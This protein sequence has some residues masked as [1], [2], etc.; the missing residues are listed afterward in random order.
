MMP[1]SYARQ[2][3]Q[4]QEQQE[5]P[6]PEL[7]PLHLSSAPT[8][9]HSE[10]AS[11][12]SAE[13]V[14]GSV[15][16]RK[17]HFGFGQQPQQWAQQ[18]HHPNRSSPI[19]IIRN[20]LSESSPLQTGSSDDEDADS[21]VDVERDA[22]KLKANYGDNVTAVSLNK[23][24]SIASKTLLKAPY[25]GSMSQPDMFRSHE[26][27]P[28]SLTEGDRFHH[29]Y[30]RHVASGT[31][32]SNIESY[33]SLRESHQQGLFLD[34][35]ASYR[36]VRSGQIRPLDHRRRFS[37]GASP[38]AVSIGERMQQTRKLKELEKKTKGKDSSAGLGKAIGASSLSAMMDEVSKNMDVQDASAVCPVAAS[39]DYGLNSNDL[40][41]PQSTPPHTMDIPV[42]PRSS[43]G[44]DDFHQRRMMSTSLTGLELL[45][46][47]K[48]LAVPSDVNNKQ[49][50]EMV[51]S[52][53]YL[54]QT[55]PPLST[56][57]TT[58]DRDANQFQALSRSMSDPTPHLHNPALVAAMA[59]NH[60]L[61]SA[62]RQLQQNHHH[63]S[64]NSS[65]AWL[66]YMSR[67]APPMVPLP[68]PIT[69]QQSA[70]NPFN[71]TATQPSTD[72]D[73]DTDAAF[74]M[75]LE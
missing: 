56:N 26:M 8:Q 54:V 42:L 59:L 5:Q 55:D 29:D 71:D 22:L 30:Y 74:D 52:P 4:Q 15:D 34:G 28:M 25:L 9:I 10:W 2:H 68:P 61:H 27:P 66:P 20:P 70:V 24:E 58:G 1:R 31:S 69:Q 6:P 18:Q 38:P 65:P 14:Q 43:D 67:V 32:S 72:H 57:V 44:D 45:M 50:D 51:L 53:K 41:C 23:M 37:H 21:S 75:D 40:A 17:E 11:S 16:C 35:P 36:D 64:V 19:A 7:S 47:T 62:A 33:G 49:E 39:H 73:P 46:T 3:G 48:Q 63:H 12:S 60:N 13:S